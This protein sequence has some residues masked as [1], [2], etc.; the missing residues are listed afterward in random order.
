MIANKDDAVWDVIVIG[1]G[2]AGLMAAITCARRSRKVLILE[3]HSKP[4]AK[5]LISGGGRCNLTNLRVTEKDYHTGQPRTVRNILSAFPVDQTLAFFHDLGVETVFE[6]GTKYFPEKQSARAILDALL[7]E[8]KRLGVELELAKKV[9]DI[10]GREGAFQ[11]TGKN[12]SYEAKRIL[13]ATG[14]LS[15]PET[16]SDGTGYGFAKCFGHRM[17]PT[18]PALTSFL[19]D[20]PHWKNL[21]GITVPVKLKLEVDGKD[22]ASSEGVMLLTHTGFSGPA[23]LDISGVWCR[24]LSKQKKILA[25]FLPQKIETE[26]R[27]EI[28]RA[29]DEH[30]KASWKR[31]LSGYF[32]DRLVEVLLIK[33]DVMSG[34]PIVNSSRQE[35]EDVMK[36]L[37]RFFLQVSGVYGYEK[38][39]V[40]S[41]GVNL[42]DL[43]SKTLESKLCPG[44][45]FAG[46]ILDVDGRIGG[47]NLQWAWASGFVAGK[48]V[49]RKF[50]T[51]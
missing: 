17:V 16:G 9:T 30:P 34:K 46:E 43:D 36:G 22:I 50:R 7:G 32:P 42:D 37:R 6:E 49:L 31:F 11:I 10:A 15:Y 29:L 45:F 33:C 21:A 40:T 38:A 26:F 13:I 41:G 19:T 8:I 47:F 1:A 18:S 3:G 39:E 23:V 44:M 14:G 24:C 35:R 12:F 5:L 20:D 27:R 48:S 51:N 2:P 28:L 25:D 4:G